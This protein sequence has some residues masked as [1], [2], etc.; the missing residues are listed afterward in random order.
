MEENYILGIA[1]ILTGI[2]LFFLGVYI[3]DKI[4]IIISEFLVAL[5][6][7]SLIVTSVR[8]SKKRKQNGNRKV[9]KEGYPNNDATEQKNRPKATEQESQGGKKNGIRNSKNNN[10]LRK[11]T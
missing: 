4:L 1:G 5:S 10:E 9:Y 11:S 3:S 6:V 2:F 7:V 8:Q